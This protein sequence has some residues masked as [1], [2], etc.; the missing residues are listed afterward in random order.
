ALRR[1][2]H[3]ARALRM[4]RHSLQSKRWRDLS[5]LRDDVGERGRQGLYGSVR[6]LLD[7][8]R[9]GI[10]AEAAAVA[11]ELQLLRRQ[12]ETGQD[13]EI[14][15]RGVGGRTRNGDAL[16]MLGVADH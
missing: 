5:C 1:G 3:R 4:Q 6:R 16:D 10:D 11:V 9:G 7:R 15:T 14:L 2:V 8:P 13:L 12:F